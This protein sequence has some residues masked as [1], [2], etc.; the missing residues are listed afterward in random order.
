MTHQDRPRRRP[1]AVL[2]MVTALLT[3]G[4]P[5]AASAATTP[6]P[7]RLYDYGIESY[8]TG[9]SGTAVE[10]MLRNR[11]GRPTRV[12]ESKGCELD[13][14]AKPL[15]T[16]VWGNFSV[17]FERAPAL[18]LRGWQIGHGVTSSRLRLPYGITTATPYRTAVRTI[19][20]ARTAW[21]DTFQIMTIRTSRGPHMLWWGEHADGRGRI[22]GITNDF[23]P[24]E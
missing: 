15:R 21:D 17:T 23:S 5:G 19:P 24:C 6:P 12:V 7:V 22:E 16:V 4:A 11:L 10:A 18:R 3:L 1:R 20:R 8:R 2:L 14:Q 9:A 13:S